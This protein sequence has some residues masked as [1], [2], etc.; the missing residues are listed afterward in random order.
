MY[1]NEQIAMKS[2]EAVLST[3]EPY[4]KGQL[5]IKDQVPSFEEKSVLDLI[6]TSI[7]H[8]MTLQTVV[9]IKAPCIIIGDLHGNIGDLINILKNFNDYSNF[10]FLFLGDY[11]DRGLN[12]IEVMLLLLSMMCKYPNQFYLLRGNHEFAHI[13]KEYGF[14]EEIFIVYRDDNLWYE[15]QDVFSWLPLSAIVNDK[16]FC[17]HGGLSP[18]LRY[19][20]EINQIQRPIENYDGNT[21]IS[22]LVWSDPH[23]QVTTFCEN[24]RGSGVLFGNSALETF[25]TENNLKL[26]IRAHQ[27]VADG[28]M[29]FCS[30]AG[31]TLFSSSEY[32]RMI[33]NKSGIIK[34][35]P[36]SKMEFY[37][38]SR[39]S[40]EGNEPKMTLFLNKNSIGMHRSFKQPPKPL[41]G[42]VPKNQQNTRQTPKKNNFLASKPINKPKCTN[43]TKQPPRLTR[44]PKLPVLGKAF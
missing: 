4:L 16:I 31:V 30:N 15:F 5:D 22:D 36:K 19:V 23:D 20:D 12:S 14:Y 18:S 29:T 28:F 2:F 35:Y 7:Q 33:H 43:N 32:C 41:P 25:L 11:V 27:C 10:T 34:V 17:V 8:L 3:F 24:H 39:D 38:F 44:T 9:K 37:S 13:N 40:L 21:L 6:K 42:I 1:V 26:L